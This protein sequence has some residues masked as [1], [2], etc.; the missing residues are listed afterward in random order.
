[1]YGGAESWLYPRLTL[2]GQALGSFIVA[3]EV[4]IRAR[5]ASL[6]VDTI[7]YPFVYPLFKGVFG[8]KVLAYVHYPFINYDVLKKPSF[9]HFYNSFLLTAYSLVGSFV[10]CALCNSSWTFNHIKGLWKGCRQRSILYPPCDLSPFLTLERP[11]PAESEFVI[12]SLSQ[13]RPEKNHRLQLEIAKLISTHL[14]P[15]K[16]VFIGGCRNERD[17]QRV[18]EL[19]SYA[20]ELGISQSTQ[21]LINLPFPSLMM[22]LSVAH[23]GLH[24]MFEEHFGIG[25]VELMAGGLITIAHNSGGPRADIIRPGMS[26][27]IE[28]TKCS[29]SFF[30]RWLFGFQCS[31]IR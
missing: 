3:L 15:A 22:Q 26:K 8:F 2:L 23:V 24:T 28:I 20:S 14:A 12:L 5:D 18:E 30:S 4:A 27:R 13:F 1:M 9:K 19:K 7:G 29:L 6:I 11:E 10:D 31:R 21:F 16:F 25:I 17:H